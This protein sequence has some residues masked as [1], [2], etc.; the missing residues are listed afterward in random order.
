MHGVGEWLNCQVCYADGGQAAG[1]MKSDLIPPTKERQDAGT[2]TS[3]RKK[4]AMLC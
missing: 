2:N 3:K 1:L 4:G